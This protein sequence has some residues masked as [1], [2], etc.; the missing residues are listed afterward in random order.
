[1]AHITDKFMEGL[2]QKVLQVPFSLVP[3]GDEEVRERADRLERTL[4]KWK[5]ISTFE[6][7]DLNNTDPTLTIF[8]EPK[9]TGDRDG[10]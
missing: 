10:K 9:A 2:I 7:L 4:D 1:M 3:D 5:C 8:H 6:G